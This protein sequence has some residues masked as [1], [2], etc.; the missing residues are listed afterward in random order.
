MDRD[1]FASRVDDTIDVEVAVLT[2][3]AVAAA[4]AGLV[5]VGQALARTI[6][7]HEL[8]QEQPGGARA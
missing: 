8:E 1:D 6:G 5:V 7:G 4:L 2:V 3:F